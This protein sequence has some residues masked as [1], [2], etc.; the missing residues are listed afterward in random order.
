MTDKIIKLAR[1]AGV[2]LTENDGRLEYFERFYELAV[3][4]ERESNDRACL[5]VLAESRA[6]VGFVCFEPHELTV[7]AC[8]QA[9][10]ARTTP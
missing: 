1:A 9:I 7:S 6:T 5:A 3:K 8:R 10:S 2:C 4:A